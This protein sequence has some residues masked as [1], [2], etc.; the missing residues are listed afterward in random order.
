MSRRCARVAVFVR[1]RKLFDYTLPPAE[2]SSLIGRR[3]LVPFGSKEAVGIVMETSATPAVAANKLKPIKRVYDDMPPLPPAT[4]NLIRFCADYY[5]SPPGQAAACALPVFF[6]RANTLRPPAGYRLHPAADSEMLAALRGNAAAVVHC[7]Q[8]GAK[9]LTALR[10]TIPY[11]HAALKKLLQLGCIERCH[12]LPAA[13]ATTAAAPAPPLSTAQRRLLQSMHLHA[14]FVPHLLFGATGSGKSELYMH[15]TEQV[16]AQGRQVLLLTPEIHLTPALEV[17]LRQRF[18]ARTIA[19][20]HSGLAEGERARRWLMAHLGEADIVLGTRLAAFT[21]MP[22]LGLII[23]DEEHDASFKQEEGGLLFSARDIAVWRAKNAGIPFLAGSATPSL[24]S[25]HN[26]QRGKWRLLALP[27]RVHGTRPQIRLAA[28]GEETYHGMGTLFVRELSQALAGGEQCL[29]FLNRRGY[30]PALFCHQCNRAQKCPRC[31][32]AM[33]VH[34]RRQL[35]V[36]H[37]CGASAPLRAACAQCGGALAAAGSGTQRVEEA[38][39]KLFPHLSA[40]RIDSDAGNALPGNAAAI[41]SGAV[42]LLIGTQLIAKGHDFPKLS[43][44]GILNADAALAAADLRAEERL[45]ALLSQVVGRGTRNPAG[46]RVLVQTRHP[47][48]PFYRELQRDDVHA[49][50]QRLLAERRAAGMPPFAHLAVLRSKDKSLPRLDAFMQRA[51]TQA[52]RQAPAAVQVFDAV[53]PPVEKINHWHRR[54]LLLHARQRA[55][56]QRF[57]H[58]Y[59]QT[60]PAG[61]NWSIE[62]DPLTV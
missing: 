33:T 36:C 58:T 48:H 9:S 35:L 52:R 21:P 47:A 53:A 43:F 31:S 38:L 62:V 2:D 14:N 40:L 15:A 34:R 24:E 3:V 19:V 28:E 32:S 59:V 55:P 22:R 37:L 4:L 26:A 51:L 60:L 45:F 44:I 8:G 20:L 12:L 41:R 56:L 57:L 54:Q 1:A 18:P 29:I 49:C 30:A 7:L 25:L 61:G 13:A 6:R 50:W 11:P 27:Q 46:C 17:L 23:V 16:L 42:Q 5:H 39:A 10:T